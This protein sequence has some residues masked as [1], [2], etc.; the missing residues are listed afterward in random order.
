MS[1]LRHIS[2]EKSKC[3]K[4]L[5]KFT[6]HKCVC[7]VNAVP[8]PTQSTQNDKY[9]VKPPNR[10]WNEIGS[11]VLTH[12]ALH[13]KLQAKKSR[14]RDSSLPGCSAAWHDHLDERPFYYD[15]PVHLLTVTNRQSIRNI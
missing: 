12:R 14:V 1:Y 7:N 13:A 9:K 3:L 8:N 5:M 11:K 4:T 2:N 6:I 10:D 15:V